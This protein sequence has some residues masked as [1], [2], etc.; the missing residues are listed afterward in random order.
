MRVRIK[1]LAHQIKTKGV[2][3]AVSDTKGAHVGNLVVTKTKVIWYPGK[4]HKGKGNGHGQ[5]WPRFIAR[6]EKLKTGLV[7]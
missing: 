3:L 5:T 7:D 6:M 4:T 1:E 2:T